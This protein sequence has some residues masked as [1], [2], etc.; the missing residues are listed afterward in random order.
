MATIYTPHFVQF[1]DDDGAPLAGGKLYTYSAGTTTP[2]ATY[3]TAS[4]SVENANPIILDSQGRAVLFLDGSY[5]FY[6]TDSADVAIGPNGGVTDNI[7]SFQVTSGGAIADGDYGDIVVSGSGT[8]IAIDTNAVTTSKIADYSVSLSKLA[9][10][11]AN[12]VLANAT[13]STATPSAVAL[14]ASQLLGR[15]ATGDI[16]AITLGSGL[17]MSGTTLSTGGSTL[18][19]I[20]STQTPT[21]VSSVIFSSIPAT[22]KRL[23]LMW[24]GVSFTTT[25]TFTISIETTG[26]ASNVFGIYKSIRNTTVTGVYGGSTGLIYTAQSIPLD[27]NSKG[28]LCINNYASTTVNKDYFVD[29]I[30]VSNSAANHGRSFGWIGKDTN[31]DVLNFDPF[32]A[33]DQITI[34][35]SSGTFDAGSISLWGET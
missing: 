2:K 24:H 17:S 13:S 32:E 25:N 5:K 8:T 33:I 15:G 29:E 21:G 6:L 22:Y 28:I 10:Q 14:S 11:A 4:A 35:A 34:A 16:A 9:T 7:T 12:T 23:Y 31:S 1:F 20:G 30:I 26:S 19:Q 18:T 27:Q 3:T